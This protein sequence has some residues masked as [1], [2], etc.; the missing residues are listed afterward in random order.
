MLTR[1]KGKKMK[2][3]AFVLLI[4]IFLLTGCSK[5]NVAYSFPEVDEES[6]VYCYDFS[7]DTFEALPDV[8]A[9]GLPISN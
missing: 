3:L 8:S 5:K 9:S 2:K 1:R 6:Q 7:T 4:S